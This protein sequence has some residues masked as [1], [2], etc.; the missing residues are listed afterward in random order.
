MRTEAKSQPILV[1]RFAQSRLYDTTNRLIDERQRRRERSDRPH[2]IRP[3]CGRALQLGRGRFALIARP[4]HDVFRVSAD[5]ACRLVP[6][7]QP[8]EK[9]LGARRRGGG[10][11]TANRHVAIGRQFGIHH[12]PSCCIEADA[13]SRHARDD[14]RDAPPVRGRP[15]RVSRAVRQD[16][17]TLALAGFP[18]SL[19]RHGRGSVPRRRLA[20][21]V[22]P[23]PSLVRAGSARA[24]DFHTAVTRRSGSISGSR[25]AF[26]TSRICSPSAELQFRTRQS[27][28]G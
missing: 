5:A 20:R 16:H 26:V 9:T 28:V 21:A 19:R 2:E 7:A 15:A 6:P 24:P 25:L 3:R 27:D 11:R 12:H 22:W 1:K 23:G 14:E 17:V 13:L 4:R 10:R 18:V 8:F